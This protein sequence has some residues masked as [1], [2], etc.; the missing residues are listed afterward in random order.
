MIRGLHNIS[1]PS[2]SHTMAQGRKM[3]LPVDPASLIY[4]H[5]EYVSGTAAPQGTHGVAISKLNLLDVL[6]EQVNKIKSNVP[7]N[8]N[9]FNSLVESFKNQ[10]LQAKEANAAMPYLP[11][12]S[13]PSG[14]LFNLVV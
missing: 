5:F 6:I 1:M 4:S 7:V 2:V 10:I 11:L 9:S 12:P 13:A 8:N 3:S 14:A